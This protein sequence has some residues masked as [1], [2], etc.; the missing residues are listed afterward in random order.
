MPLV[1]PY[2]YH[3]YPTTSPTTLLIVILHHL[4]SNHNFLTIFFFIFFFHL[5]YFQYEFKRHFVRRFCE[6]AIQCPGRLQLQTHHE[7]GEMHNDS[8]EASK[9]QCNHESDEIHTHYLE[10]RQK[11]ELRY[12]RHY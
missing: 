1:V 8:H 11:Y 12:H 3:P 5:S 7:A 4:L 6:D 9:I 10:A 2:L